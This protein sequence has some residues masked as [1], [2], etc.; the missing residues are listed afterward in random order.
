MFLRR[1]FLH[2]DYYCLG[3]VPSTLVRDSGPWPTVTWSGHHPHELPSLAQPTRVALGG[4]CLLAVGA[5]AFRFERA[6][7]TE[8]LAARRAGKE[9]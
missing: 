5:C 6:I 4:A 3:T 2:H 9:E 8:L 1:K 7:G